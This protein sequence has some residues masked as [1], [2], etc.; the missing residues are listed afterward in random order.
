MP[1]VPRVSGPSVQQQAAPNVQ[2]SI[3]GVTADAFG[4]RT[5]ANL[6]D[7]GNTLQKIKD[8]D[9]ADQVFRAETALKTDYLSFERS[10]LERN[11]ADAK[12][13]GERSQKWW[14]E[15]QLKYSEGLTNGR[16]SR[17]FERSRTAVQMAGNE[18]LL[19]HETQQRNRSL[20]E[21]TVAQVQSASSLAIA[22]PSPERLQLSRQQ[23]VTSN[24]VLGQLRGDTP[25]IVQQRTQE[26]LTG[27][28]KGVVMKMVD[29]DPD[30]AKAYYYGNRKEITGAEQVVIEKALKQGGLVL[31]AQQGADEIMPKFETLGEANA[32][33]EKNYS[34]EEERAV[35]SEVH[36][37]FAVRE[38]G[39]NK[40]KQEAYGQGQLLVVRGQPI[41]QSL[42]LTM[43]DGHYAALLEHREARARRLEI[44]A[45]E[46]GVKT[47]FATYE[48]LNELSWR[49][50]QEFIARDLGRYQDKLSTADLKKFSEDKQRLGTAEGVKGLQSTQQQ[51][52]TAVDQ[53]RLGGEGN[54]EKRGLFTRTVND[55][56]AD[57]QKIV[58]RPLKYEEVQKVIDQQT[59]KVSVPGFFYDSDRRNFELTGQERAKN[60]VV[61]VPDFDRQQ[62]T[63][64]LKARNKPVTDKAIRDLYLQVKGLK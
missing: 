12:G 6:A 2:Q 53:M 45:R 49:S 35:K 29:D 61:K 38:H 54:A 32:Y 31:K 46:K 50:P 57:E 58:G 30:A 63:E 47:D 41:P 17:I 1:Q 14:G 18:T 22:D 24:Q 3:G 19:R 5:A 8:Q 20:A 55:A 15:A 26:A 62:I 39:T 37:R 64:A 36:Q 34:G 11:G 60:P 16:Q 59:L 51:I 43:G 13:A 23:I 48:M 42:A 10:E 27:M 25:E 21:S 9:D 44:E 33:I 52:S 28:H 4:A 40:A 7:A 56:L